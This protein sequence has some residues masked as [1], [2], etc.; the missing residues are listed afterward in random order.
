MKEK[1]YPPRGDRWHTATVAE[2]LMVKGAEAEAV[3]ARELPAEGHRLSEVG[4][5]LLYEGFLP[6]GAGLWQPNVVS[7]L[8]EQ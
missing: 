1:L 3:R 5:R 7:V 8:I 4:R 2:L 6:K